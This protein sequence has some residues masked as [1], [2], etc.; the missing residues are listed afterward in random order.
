M[1][2]SQ[3]LG[4]LAHRAGQQGQGYEEFGFYSVCEDTCTG[5]SK[6]FME[7]KLKMKYILV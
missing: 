5:Y 4:D 1:A 2:M 6:D 3:G 7:K